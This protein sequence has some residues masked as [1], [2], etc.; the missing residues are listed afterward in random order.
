MALGGLGDRGPCFIRPDAKANSNT[1][2]SRDA[3]A[4]DVFA[5]DAAKQTTKACAKPAIAAAD[6]WCFE[7]FHLLLSGG[8]DSGGAAGRRRHGV[9]K[10]CCPSRT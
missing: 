4:T 8:G 3:P 7:L 10:G 5:A 1:L 6:V 9:L 2:S